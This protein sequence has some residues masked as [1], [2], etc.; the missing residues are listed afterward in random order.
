MHLRNRLFFALCLASLQP[1]CSAGFL[2]GGGDFGA[3]P[4]GVQDLSF[5]RGLV[6]AG[7]VPPAEAVLVEGMFSEHDLPLSGPPCAETLCLR[8][9]VGVAPGLAGSPRVFAQVGLSSAVEPDAYERPPLALVAVVD[10]SGSMGWDQGG[11]TAGDYAESLLYQLTGALDGGDRFA[12]VTFGDSVSVPVGWTAGDDPSLP[13]AIDALHEAGST[14]ME[15]GLEKGFELAA[16]A[17]GQ[18]REVRV[19]L[20][21]DAQPNVGATSASA[22]EAMATEA[23]GEGVGLTVLG[24]GLGMGAEVVSAMSHLRGGN[25]FSFP[26]D[27]YVDAFMADNWPWFTAPIA[28][29][30]EVHATPSAGLSVAASYGFPGTDGGPGTDLQVASVF[31]S[32]RRGGLLLELAPPAEPAAGQGVALS[33]SYEDRAGTSHAAT[34]EPSWDGAPVDARGVS[35]PEPGIERAVSLAL[36]TTALRGALEGYGEDPAGAKAKLDAALERLAADAAATGDAELQAEA[37]FWG[38]LSDLM[39]SGAT[40]GGLY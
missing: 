21:T 28:Y 38:G 10:V 7:F 22:F 33:L 19:V 40:Q 12:L 25:A 8:G 9:A 36:F 34:L 32:K 3:T 5:A 1:A 16:E 14:D 26:E 24:L 2:G 6:E 17:L 39:A 4:G 31:L 35:L 20:F 23:A 29:D 27:S 13:E 30:L 37:D 18:G 15:S 11:S